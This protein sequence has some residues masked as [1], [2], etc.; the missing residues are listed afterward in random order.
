[1]N[2][3]RDSLFDTLL[4]VIALGF[5]ALGVY[6][7]VQSFRT[8]NDDDREEFLVTSHGRKIYLVPVPVPSHPVDAIGKPS[9]EP[10]PGPRAVP[11]PSG[12]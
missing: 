1:M 5:A 2:D 7:I 11:E 6:A 12:D 8:V 10:P 3:E 4:N 9:P